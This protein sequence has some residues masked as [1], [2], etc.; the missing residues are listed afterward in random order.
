MREYAAARLPEYMVPAA[1]VVLDA[2]PLTPSG[3]VDRKALPAPDYAAAAAGGRGPAGVREELLCRVFAEVLGVDRVGPEDSFFALGGHSLLAVSLAERLRQQGLQVP[4]RALF[5]A[6]TPAG[7]AVV[8]VAGGAV[9]VPP[10]LIP[11]GAAVI[12]PQMLTLVS[13]T[14]EQIAGISAGVQGGAANIADIYPLA[15]LQEG[16]FFHHLMAGQDGTDVY[17]QP[18][19]LGFASRDRLEAFLAAVQRV[20]DRHDIYRTAVA[21][22]GLPEPVQ[23]VWRAARLP[24]TEI[25]L[26]TATSARAATADGTSGV[27]D[28]L[29]A[30]AGP[31][32]E[33]TAAPLLRALVA[34]EPGTGRWLALLQVHH[35]LQDHAGLDVVLAEIAAMLAGDEGRL[36]EPLP[37]REFVGHARLG[38]PREEHERFFAGLL[39]DVTEPTAPFGLLDTRGDGTAAV[40]ARLAV[41]PGLAAGVRDRARLLGVSAATLFH[42]VWARVLAAVSGRDDVVFGTVLFGRMNAGAGADRVPGPFINT[43]PVRVRHRAGRG[44]P[45][46]WPRCRASWP[47]CWPTSMRRWR[48]PSRPAGCPRLPRCSPPCSTTGTPRGLPRPGQDQRAGAGLAGIEVI[49]S[50]DRTNYPLTSQLMTAGRGSSWWRTRWRRSIRGWCARWCVPR[51]PGWSPRWSTLRVL[52]CGRCRCW[53]RR[54]GTSWWRGGMTRRCRCRRRDGGASCWPGGWRSARMRWRW[55]AGMRCCR[56]GGCGRGRGCWRGG[57]RRRGRGRSRWWGCCWSGGRSWS[58]R[59]WRC[60]GRGR[61]TCR[62]IRVTPAGRVAF[63][64]ADSGAGLV[65]SRAGAGRGAGSAGAV[66]R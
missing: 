49:F 18:Y 35:L 38:V 37:F 22:E 60:G 65:V 46:R 62:W 23:V 58:R 19:V 2:L 47:G 4:V 63:M 7:L 10:N 48:W 27:V 6:P 12:T 43:L 53:I 3:K 56:T 30:A 11:A 33:L 45:R 34:A 14:E 28:R 32:M 39:G 26:E 1:V 52:R 5:E 64:L 54:S 9:A 15:P 31:R 16:L 42:L 20:I 24:V 57:W 50:R 41:E 21:W 8:A 44:R 40:T 59:S 13:L 51:R 55:C 25:T 66:A 36:P 29:L 61:R 17:L